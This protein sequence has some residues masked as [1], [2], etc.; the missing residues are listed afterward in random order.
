MDVLYK[1]CDAAHAPELE[2][3]MKPHAHLAFETEPTAPAWADKAFDGRRTYVR[4]LQDCCNPAFLQ[5]A[6][7]E[8]SKVDWDVVDF[9]TG[10]MPFVSKPKALAEQF[11]KST[12]NFME[13]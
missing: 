10:H 7:L 11:I 13:L 1:D 3:S 2:G 4:T 5:D 8:K 12:K 6:W 9:K